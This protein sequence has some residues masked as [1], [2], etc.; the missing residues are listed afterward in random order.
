MSVLELSQDVPREMFV[1][2]PVPRDGLAESGFGVLIPIMASTMT[3]QNA[4]ALFELSNQ[5]D[6][7]HAI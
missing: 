1:V 5:I 2:F 6:V 3:K 4:A 7:F